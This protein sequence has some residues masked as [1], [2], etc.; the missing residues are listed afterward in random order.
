M[1][2]RF[3]RKSFISQHMTAQPKNPHISGKHVGQ[4]FAGK[5]TDVI[6][7]CSKIQ[8]FFCVMF[9]C[10]HSASTGTMALYVE[11]WAVTSCDVQHVAIHA[12][13][14]THQV[15]QAATHSDV[16]SRGMSPCSPT[17]MHS[18]AQ[19]VTNFTFTLS[20]VLWANITIDLGQEKEFSF[21]FYF[22]PC[23]WFC[24]LFLKLFFFLMS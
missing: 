20:C 8:C 5:C 10:R 21:S 11:T 18:S 24:F 1:I 6:W 9:F 4:L 14:L 22:C 17:L 7:E 15:S 13:P 23:C 19:D 2:Y 16:N 3:H 12:F